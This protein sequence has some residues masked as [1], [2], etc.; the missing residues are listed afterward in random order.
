MES[1][2][3]QGAAYAR[4]CMI[5]KIIGLQ[6]EI[7]FDEKKESYIILQKLLIDIEESY[8]GMFRPFK[9]ETM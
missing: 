1:E 2:F 8:G 9:G 6:E 5:A 4:D 3:N 7:G